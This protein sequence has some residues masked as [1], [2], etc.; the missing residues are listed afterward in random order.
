MVAASVYSDMERVGV[1]LK[2]EL[3]SHFLG[4]AS[5][6]DPSNQLV[7]KALAQ[8]KEI[9]GYTKGL[10]EAAVRPV[11]IATKEAPAATNNRETELVQELWN[12]DVGTM[13]SKKYAEEFA[14]IA[15]GRKIPEEARLEIQELFQTRWDQAMK[16]VPQLREKVQGFLANNDR[17]GN[18]RY[19][20]ALVQ[21]HTGR[22]LEALMRRHVSQAPATKPAPK[23]AQA[24]AAPVATAGFT[25]VT[26]MPE[27]N[28]I[29]MLQTDS[30]M[31]R[32]GRAVLKTGAKVQWR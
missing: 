2:V 7:A 11:T 32:A 20:G 9:E 31:L 25:R 18:R 26:G 27:R 22:I 1:P 15:A 3:L 28:T 4:E 23:P 29:D 16:S 24:V 30:D 12:G 14:R 8:F 17:E 5:A 13:V 10:R 21:E 19:Y 6:S